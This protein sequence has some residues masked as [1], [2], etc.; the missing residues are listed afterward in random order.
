MGGESKRKARG[1]P[2]MYT[3]TEMKMRVK[4]LVWE[5]RSVSLLQDGESADREHLLA[6]S[7]R[8]WFPSFCDA[9]ITT[10]TFYA[11]RELQVSYYVIAFIIINCLTNLYQ[12]NWF[13]GKKDTRRG[14]SRF[15][16]STGRILVAPPPLPPANPN[17][18][19]ISLGFYVYY[20][21]QTL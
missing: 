13:F 2:Q 12:R 7:Q 1:R 14:P 21:K 11:L 5:G 4:V 6:S 10:L 8:V 18:A 3:E 19:K 9:D 15:L 20:K 16:L 17:P